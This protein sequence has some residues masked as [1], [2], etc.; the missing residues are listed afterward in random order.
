MPKKGRKATRTTPGF[1][2][3]FKGNAQQGTLFDVG[4]LP[5]T[6]DEIGPRG[7][8]LNRSRQF[9][10]IF[11]GV[12]GT[13]KPGTRYAFGAE[14]PKTHMFIKHVA[15]DPMDPEAGTRPAVEPNQHP[16]G[17]SRVPLPPPE[18]RNA[19]TKHIQ[20]AQSLERAKSKL[21]DTLA[22][23]T[24]DPESLKGL[25]EI[26]MQPENPEYAGRYHG[27]P[28]RQHTSIQLAVTKESPEKT[29]WPTEDRPDIPFS[30]PSDVKR[31][32]QRGPV[33]PH[34]EM[35]LLHELGHHVSAMTERPSSEYRDPRQ[36]G[37][38]EGFADAFAVGHYREDTRTA[39]WHGRIDPREHTYLG[40]GGPRDWQKFSV[41]PISQYRQALGAQ[42]VPPDKGESLER[43][44]IQERHER[45]M[46]DEYLPA[47]QQVFSTRIEGWSSRGATPEEHRAGV[48]K[49]ARQITNTRT[50]R[51]KQERQEVKRRW[52]VNRNS[53]FQGSQW[54]G[55][56]EE[57]NER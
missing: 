43:G 36:M 18:K 16:F 13:I 9:Q 41:S 22:R 42:N 53:A 6:G 56:D 14:G 52:G 38:E 3:P 46:L 50:G 55:G 28:H 29:S 47:H 25:S 21:V 27:P 45:P 49:K 32:E 48:Y 34:S 1:T 4:T 51:F 44:A 37:T 26:S 10:A 5:K 24:V 15:R 7:Y 39:R 20:L 35:T 23:S 11:Q 8:S 31:P 33:D 54:A 57:S 30:Y 19:A 17:P 12:K 2:G 40:R